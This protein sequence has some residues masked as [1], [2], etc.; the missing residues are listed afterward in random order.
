[1]GGYVALA[2]AELYPDFVKGLVLNSTQK[3]IT[4]SESK[5]RSRH[6]SGKTKL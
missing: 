6:Q 3:K 2:F 1:M 4:T 5:Q